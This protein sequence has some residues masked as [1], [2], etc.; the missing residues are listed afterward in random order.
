MRR[1]VFLVMQYHLPSG[2]Y[3]TELNRGPTELHCFDLLILRDTLCKTPCNPVV[4]GIIPIG[5]KK[6]QT[7]ITFYKFSRSITQ[8]LNHPFG[9]FKGLRV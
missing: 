4:N 7:L 8:S 3:T 9:W 1:A 2:F 6:G 5:N